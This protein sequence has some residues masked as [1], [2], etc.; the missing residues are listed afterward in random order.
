VDMLLP[1]P[2]RMG[3]ANTRFG[4]Q[5]AAV[6][7]GANGRRPEG[8]AVGAAAAESGYL[9]SLPIRLLPADELTRER[10]RMFG[11]SRI[12]QLAAISRSAGVAR[13]RE[14][15]GLTRERARGPGTR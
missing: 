7:G 14:Q 3:I 13:F 15:G 11:L 10:L 5:V 1:G 2:L 6:V 4:A 9:G 12:G 8:V